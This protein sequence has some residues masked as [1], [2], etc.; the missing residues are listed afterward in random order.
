VA[1]KW[2]SLNPLIGQIISH[3]RE[4]EKLGGGKGVVYKAEDTRASTASKRF[5]EN[6]I[7]SPSLETCE[8]G[9]DLLGNDTC[10]A[11]LIKA[12]NN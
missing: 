6:A 1:A 3:Y 8:L 12:A 4:V 11:V 5:Y 9:S 10:A 2:R 7:N